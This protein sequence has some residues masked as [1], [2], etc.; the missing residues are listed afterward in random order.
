MS[1]WLSDKV[2]AQLWSALGSVPT[3]GFIFALGYL[4]DSKQFSEE[5]KFAIAVEIKKFLESDKSD[6]TKLVKDNPK[7]FLP[8]SMMLVAGYLLSI[9]II[10]ATLASSFMLALKA[11]D[12]LDKKKIIAY[13][14]KEFK[15][16]DEATKKTIFAISAKVVSEAMQ[17]LVVGTAAGIGA[18]AGAMGAG[19]DARNLGAAGGAMVGAERARNA[20]DKAGAARRKTL[21]AVA[22]G[23]HGLATRASSGAAS[24]AGMLTSALRRTKSTGASSTSSD[25]ESDNGSGSSSRPTGR[26]GG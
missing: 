10:G 20:L 9:P 26:K 8:P 1:G 11:T 15:L 13:L 18:A 2:Q 23:A 3:E 14:D 19:K 12:S 6:L 25:S 17:S 16:A 21:G 24:T 5:T 7:L 4:K 22:K